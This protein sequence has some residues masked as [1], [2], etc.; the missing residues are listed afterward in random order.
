MIPL[1]V[2]TT[3]NNGNKK[4]INNVKDESI[5]SNPYIRLKMEYPESAIFPPIDNRD[6]NND[7]HKN[8]K[9]LLTD[10][11]DPNRVF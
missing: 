4:L 3:T 2:S 11:Y 5:E 7:D 8:K 10:D 9:E 6:R 1:D